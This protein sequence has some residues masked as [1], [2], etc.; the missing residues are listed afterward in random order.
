MLSYFSTD[1]TAFSTDLTAANS[2]VNIC[3]SGQIQNSIFYIAECALNNT[4]NPTH[5]QHRC[6]LTEFLTLLFSHRARYRLFCLRLHRLYFLPESIIFNPPTGPYPWHP[7][8]HKLNTT[9][10][11]NLLLLCENNCKWIVFLEKGVKLAEFIFYFSTP[12]CVGCRWRQR[13]ALGKF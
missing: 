6:N 13:C 3:V 11:H 7:L 9:S 8:L 1:L 2:L 4:I 5:R 10:L 12:L